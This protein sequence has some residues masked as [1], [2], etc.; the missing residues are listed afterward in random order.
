MYLYGRMRTSYL[1]NGK[2]LLTEVNGIFSLPKDLP[3]ELAAL[4]G[5]WPAEP[6]SLPED[7][8]IACAAHAEPKKEFGILHEFGL[9]QRGFT[10]T[11]P[12]LGALAL[13]QPPPSAILRPTGPGPPVWLLSAA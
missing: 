4:F 10:K 12:P 5:L 13:P 1:L 3:D 9:W 8:K 7:P 6:P 2:L 11:Q